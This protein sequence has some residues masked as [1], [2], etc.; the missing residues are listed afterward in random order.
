MPA[1]KFTDSRLMMATGRNVMASASD[2]VVTGLTTVLYAEV[3]L[4][5]APVLAASYA[6]VQIGNQAGTPAAGSIIIKLWMPT[7]STHPTPIA[8]TGY[9]NVVVNWI[10]F[11]V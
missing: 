8:A 9:A 10:A 7:D 1:I 11:G 3:S 2:T 5:T 6:T 4:E